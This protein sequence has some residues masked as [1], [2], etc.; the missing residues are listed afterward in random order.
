M[1]NIGEKRVTARMAAARAVVRMQ[2]ETLGRILAGRIEKGDVL[3]VAQMA[4]IQAAKQTWAWLPLCH[5]IPLTS[6]GVTFVDRGDELLIEAAVRAEARTGVEMEA[7]AAVTC[8][9]LTVY[10]MC[11]QYDRAMAVADVRLVR[12]TGGQGG[13]YEEAT[14]WTGASG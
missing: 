3:T 14:A 8:S 9:A 10:D 5:Q 13:D 6:V 1:V 4:G 2:P 7:L 12:K 11:K